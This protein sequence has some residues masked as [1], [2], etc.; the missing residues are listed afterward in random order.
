M[1]DAVEG[2]PVPSTFLRSWLLVVDTWRPTTT[3]GAYVCPPGQ[4]VWF[5]LLDRMPDPGEAAEGAAS[6][7]PS[8]EIDAR[9]RL[10]SGSARRGERQRMACPVAEARAHGVEGLRREVLEQKTPEEIA[11]ERARLRAAHIDADKGD[12]AHAASQPS[13][14]SDVADSL[15]SLAGSAIGT[16]ARGAGAVLGATAGGVIEGLGP[17]V[18]GGAAALAIW[19]VARR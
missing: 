3:R 11:R 6:Q 1:V 4:G 17:V 15:G 8:G 9:G 12:A 19:I 5:V 18:V 13:F 16:L 14:L 7:W 10:V 2:Y